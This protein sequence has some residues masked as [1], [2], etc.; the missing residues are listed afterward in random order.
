MKPLAI[1]LFHPF[2][3]A[4]ADCG[5]SGCDPGCASLLF[6]HDTTPGKF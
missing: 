6:R 4:L 1:S 2:R 3:A 5:Q